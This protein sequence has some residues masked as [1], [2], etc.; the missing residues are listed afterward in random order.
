MELILTNNPITRKNPYRIN[1][2]KKLPHL[3]FLDT[4]EISYEEKERVEFMYEPKPSP[5]VHVV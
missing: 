3:M 1:I 4:V 5:L 2:I